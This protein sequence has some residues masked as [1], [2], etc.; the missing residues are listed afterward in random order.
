VLCFLCFA[1]S[2]RWKA[3]A[4]AVLRGTCIP[5]NK[6]CSRSLKL[7]YVDQI[8][9][10]VVVLASTVLSWGEPKAAA[11]KTTVGSLNKVYVQSFCYCEFL[12]L[13]PSATGVRR[14]F[15]F[16]AGGSRPYSSSPRLRRR[17]WSCPSPLLAEVT[18]E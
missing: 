8:R 2:H 1:V 6:V 10:H 9:L 4:Q 16:L 7:G 11:E 5:P 17:T 13:P 18:L 15:G 3:A 12:H 14:Q